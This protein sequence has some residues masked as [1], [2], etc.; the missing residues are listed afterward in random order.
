MGEALRLPANLMGV[1]RISPLK[2]LFTNNRH[3]DRQQGNLVSH[4][5][6]NIWVVRTH[7]IKESDLM[8]NYLLIELC[9]PWL[10]ALISGT[11]AVHPA[12][13]KGDC[14]RSR[15]LR[16]T[17][18]PVYIGHDCGLAAS[19]WT[20]EHWY[21]LQLPDSIEILSSNTDSGMRWEPNIDPDNIARVGVNASVDLDTVI[22]K[23]WITIDW[24]HPVRPWWPPFLLASVCLLVSPIDSLWIDSLESCRN[25]VPTHT[26]LSILA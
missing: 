10:D 24:P 5:I 3:I 16:H 25:A 8:A 22:V 7:P 14:W 4:I 18:M 1:P 20:Y 26:I 17:Q 21:D 6:L 12:V 11:F 23:L 19:I 9:P 2:H 15:N 13:W